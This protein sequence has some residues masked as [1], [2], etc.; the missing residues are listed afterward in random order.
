MGG[1]LGVASI[2][3][4]GNGGSTSN[5]MP[6]PLEVGN[7]EGSKRSRNQTEQLK[8]DIE[9]EACFICLHVG[10]R[11]WKHRAPA[12]NNVGFNVTDETIESDFNP[13]SEN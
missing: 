8:R 6:T 3:A 7:T 12:V 10:C 2:V 11:P 13:E 4:Q 9:G 5:S 1:I